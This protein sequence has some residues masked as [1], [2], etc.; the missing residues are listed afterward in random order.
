MYAKNEMDKFIQSK[1]P[2]DN[3][4]MVAYKQ[5]GKKADKL[6]SE[7]QSACNALEIMTIEHDDCFGED[8]FSS[9]MEF[10]LEMARN[11]NAQEKVES[12][13]TLSVER[14]I[15]MRQT[16]ISPEQIKPLLPIFNGAS[17]LSILDAVDT[18]KKTLIN[19]GIHKLL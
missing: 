7:L 1:D 8:F 19:A 3:Q 16:N 12:L 9:L 17:S 15:I 5:A 4:F 2:D 13:K 11:N 6:Q 10:S 14:G 18:W